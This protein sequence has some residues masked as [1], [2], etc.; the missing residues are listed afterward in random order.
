MNSN[1]H[2][3]IVNGKHSYIT[4]QMVAYNYLKKN[5]LDIHN[6]S[7]LLKEN[8]YD[9]FIIDVPAVISH[10]DITQFDIDQC[11]ETWQYSNGTFVIHHRLN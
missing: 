4:D 6:N 5:K 1:A 2:I 7:F 9:N 3:Y 11:I 10:T 8:D